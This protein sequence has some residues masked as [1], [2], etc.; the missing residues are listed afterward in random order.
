M[1]VSLDDTRGYVA[2]RTGLAAAAAG[3]TGQLRWRYPQETRRGSALKDRGPTCASLSPGVFDDRFG[4]FTVSEALQLA[5][6][7]PTTRST[8]R[9][10]ALRSAP[11]LSPMSD[12]LAPHDLGE[13]LL[14]L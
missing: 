6:V 8:D 3:S 7:R 13:G 10:R 2:G 14:R 4:V 11:I 9:S 5:V 1:E 12:E